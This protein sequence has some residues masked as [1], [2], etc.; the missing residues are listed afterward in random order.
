MASHESLPVVGILPLGSVLASE[1]GLPRCK[2][3]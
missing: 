2:S 1:Y 3:L